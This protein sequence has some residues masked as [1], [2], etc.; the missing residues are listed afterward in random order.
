[1]KQKNFRR[2]IKEKQDNKVEKKTTSMNPAVS[3]K[4]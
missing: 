2:E 4:I 3:V 1:M